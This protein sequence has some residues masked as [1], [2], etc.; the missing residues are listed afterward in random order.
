[1]PW[2]NPFNT[3][4]DGE[5]G[6]AGWG[7]SLWSFASPIL[8]QIRRRRWV[9]SGVKCENKDFICCWF[10]NQWHF[11][12]S[13]FLSASLTLSVCFSISVSDSVSVTVSVPVANLW[14]DKCPYPSKTNTNYFVYFVYSWLSLYCSQIIIY[15][16]LF[17][18]LNKY[19]R[20]SVLLS[21]LLINDTLCELLQ[22]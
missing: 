17:I 3:G 8:L 12:W 2:P 14:K 1:M 5:K 22:L 11:L 19:K 7:Q 4:M 9:S 21:T 10:R 6:G 20:L 13:L 15:I 16:Y 18:C